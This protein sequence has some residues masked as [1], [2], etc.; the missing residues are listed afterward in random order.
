M[1]EAAT[2]NAATSA[3]AVAVFGALV[4]AAAVILAGILQRQTS[5]KQ[6]KEQRELFEQQL[7]EQRETSDN[8]LKNANEQ[9]ELLQEGQITELLMRAIE[10]LGSSNTPVRI[11]SIFAL[12]RIARESENDRPYVVSTLAALIRESLPAT[13]VRESTYVPEL[14]VRKPDVQ[15]ALTILCR[16][17]LSDDRRHWADVGGLDLS[18]SDLRRAV[19]QRADL[20]CANL[21]GCRLEG[22][23]LREAKLS[24]SILNEANFG[25]VDPTNLAYRQGADLRKADLRGAKF[26]RAHNLD[27]AL[28]EGTLGLSDNRDTRAFPPN[29]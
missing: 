18:R 22:A 2:I 21:Y 1:V 20:R 3:S 10:N 26:Q 24:D 19:L 25:S 8:Q 13:S 4:G 23:D 29:D 9:L 11:G 14:Q 27:I 15:A 17:P 12:E 16:S 28:T 5:D 6:L 7:K